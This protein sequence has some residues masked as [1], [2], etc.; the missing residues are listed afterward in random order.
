MSKFDKIQ[1]PAGDKI[2]A[3]VNG[4]LQVSDRP[5]VAFIEGDGTGPDITRAS[6]HIW[7]SAVKKAYNGKREI[8]W[9]ELFAGEKPTPFTVVNS[10]CPMKLLKPS[11]NIW[12]R[13]RVR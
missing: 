2:V 13:S 7:N 8:A 1:I 10:G 5:I 9:M 4:K 3:D 12:W 6:M 11:A